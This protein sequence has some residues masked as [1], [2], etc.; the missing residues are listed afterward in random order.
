[1][2]P[3]K[4]TKLE[5]ERFFDEPDDDEEEG[6]EGLPQPKALSEKDAQE[7]SMPTLKYHIRDAAGDFVVREHMFEVSAKTLPGACRA[8]RFLNTMHGHN[9]KPQPKVTKGR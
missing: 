1:M 2:K 9:M 7:V 5:Y 6:E 8:M 4:K 3:I